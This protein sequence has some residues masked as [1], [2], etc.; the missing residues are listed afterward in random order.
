[1]GA[2]G[3]LPQSCPPSHELCP[4]RG[5][6]AP[7]VM[8]TSTGMRGKL[9]REGTLAFLSPVSAD[10]VLAFNSVG[11]RATQGAHPSS[12]PHAACGCPEK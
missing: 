7:R 1:M 6:L 9:G 2:W 8:T 4:E 5:G 12:C 11:R 10:A 3:A